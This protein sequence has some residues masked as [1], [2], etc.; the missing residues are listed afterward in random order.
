MIQE[1]TPVLTQLQTESM[2]TPLGLDT[3]APAFSWKLASDRPGAAQTAYQIV[4]SA[5]EQLTSPVWDSGLVES[6]ASCAVV[7]RGAPLLP[8]TRY[9]W[10]VTVRDELG[11]LTA[12]QI[13]W[14]ETGLMGKDRSVWDHAQW[15]GCPRRT[16]NTAALTVYQVTVDFQVEP[17]NPAGIVLAARNK[18]N[19][20]LFEV[21]MDRRIL[22]AL[23][24]CDNAW[25]G[26]YQD[27]NLPTCVTLGD[28]DGYPIPP[29]AVGKGREY[30]W[31]RI[32]ILVDQREVTVTLNGHPVIDHEPD[33]MPA[34]AP[35]V[36]RRSCLSSIGFKQLGSRA[37]YDHL[38]VSNPKTG[39]I[40]QQENFSDET[41]VFSILGSCQN[42]RL[43]VDNR[44]ELACP[45]PAVNL[46]GSFYLTK[47]VAK[48]RLYASARGFYSIAVNGQKADDAFFH[49]GFTDYRLRIA[50]QTFDVTQFLRQGINRILATVTKGYYSGYC[51]YSGPMNYGEQ[52]SFLAKLVLT[53]EDGTSSTLVTDESWLFTDRGPV[54]DADYLDGET[55]DARL[56]PEGWAEE[57]YADPRWKPCGI[58]PWPK[59]PT[60]TNGAF[61][62]EVPFE[63]TAQEGP[64]A[65][66]ERVLSPVSVT[67]NPAG[68]YVY[69]FGQNMVGTVRLTVKG[70]RGVSLKLRYGEMCYS[71]GEIYIQNVRSA[72]NTD[73][74]TLKGDPDRE[75]FV[76]SFTSHGFRY[77]EITGNGQLLADNDCVLSLEGL[78][79][80]NTPNLI[81]DFSCSDPLINQLQSNIQWGQ[82]GNSL[83]VFTDC[84]QRN[85]RMGWTGD[86]QVFAATAAFNMDIKAFMRKWLLDI[87][88]AQLMYNRRGAVPDTAPLGGDN[89][90]AGCAG[91]GDAAVIVPWKLYLACGDTRILEENYDCMAQWIAYQ[92]MESRQNYG[93]RT[94]NGTPAPQQSD[95]AF[96]PFIQVQQ[97][98]GDHLTFDPSTPFILTATAYAAHVADLMARIASILGK[99]EDA[100]AYRA[101]FE[102]VRNAFREAWV[103]KDGSLA[104][105][106]EMSK[107]EPAD[108]TGTPINRTR[109]SNEPGSTHHPSQTAYALAIDFGLMPAATMAR[110]A[111]CFVQSIR[112]AKDHL[113]V[114]FLGIAHLLPALT[115]IGE[116]E[117]AYR[118]LEQK[119]N[120]GWLYSVINGATTIWERWN[121]F[122]AETGT[123]GDV[124]MNSFNHYAYGAIGQWLYES[125]LGIRSGER[126][127]EA[128]YKRIEL[129]PIWGGSLTWAKGWHHSPYGMIASGWEYSGGRILYRCTIPANTTARVTLPLYLPEA[130]RPASGSVHAFLKSGELAVPVSCEEGCAA[131][132]LQPGCYEFIV[133]DARS[134]ETA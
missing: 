19:Y 43:S 49:P 128:G 86:G 91:W 107:S 90:P 102:Q 42:T 9:Y 1:M 57:A 103:Q 108:E 98:R 75:T 101:R 22:R 111:Q 30:K 110:T 51:G 26:S 121:S 58:L 127:S 2:T 36:P 95:L 96:T 33:L 31:N 62:R 18:D 80:C 99:E 34:S 132:E 56:E 73:I 94:V 72:A 131:F 37:E 47:E 45:V 12:G 38:I 120:P 3:P 50:Y 46:L 13:T 53:F 85:E 29:S 61:A 41:G 67:E 81:G 23:E 59:A 118:L 89:R 64:L 55:Y 83:L 117:L 54:M 124:S 14:F 15:I 126:P 35:F 5:D 116:Y 10:Q 76:P 93:L 115:R 63:L 77:V 52:N 97:S 11:Q 28:P 79:L 119:G 32:S 130:S 123:F 20:V 78:V 74:Y 129:T 113:S 112:D 84:P 70:E 6:D 88:D 8:S 134:K 68:H 66:I 92:S 105:W 82:R 4:V 17:G 40:Y 100:A 65:V 21:D 109:Y 106:G 114:G 48:A 104:Y 16:T 125:V 44:F 122:I 25:D 60:P 71:N 69:D 87:R 7:Y 133:S 27:G 24:F 39:D